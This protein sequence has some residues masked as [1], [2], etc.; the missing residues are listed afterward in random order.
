M[1]ASTC[2]DPS[3][4]KSYVEKLPLRN[5]QAAF[6]ALQSL[7]QDKLSFEPLFEVFSGIMDHVLASPDPDMA[8]A[9]LERFVSVIFSRVTFYG[10]LRSHPAVL[11]MLMRLFGSSQFL[12]DALIR[13]PEYLDW[14]AD[15]EIMK[16]QKDKEAFLRE[17]NQTLQ[18]FPKKE[19]KMHVLR[20]FKRREMLRIGTRDILGAAP[21]EITV[22]ELSHLA[23]AVMEATLALAWGECRAKYGIPMEETP[24]GRNPAAFAVI[25]MGKLGGRE[26]NYSSDIDVMFVYSAEGEV[27]APKRKKT[28]MTAHEFFNR[29]S[30]Q[31]IEIIGAK[32]KEGYVFRID[33]R[34]RPEGETGPLSR[35]LESYETYYATWGEA[36]EKL[37]LIKARPMAG[38]AKLGEDFMA[39]TRPFVYPK[40][41]H[42]A[43]LEEIRHLKKRI[44][45]KLV[46]QGA[47]YKEV[48]L[49]YGGIREIEFS[50]QLLQ[51][52]H[53]GANKR[54]RNPNTL[55]LLDDLQAAGYVNPPESQG[56]QEAYRFLRRVEH[57]LQ[58]V[59]EMQVHQLPADEEEMQKLARRIGYTDAA[60]FWKDHRRHTALVHGFHERVFGKGEAQDPA[61]DLVFLF[62]K[63]HAMKAREWLSRRGFKD[64]EQ[65]RNLLSLLAN[66]PAYMHLSAATVREFVLLAPSLMDLLAACA[67]PDMALNAFERMVSSQG[68]RGPFYKLLKENEKLLEW[69]VKL[70]S[71]SPLLADIL[72]QHP[73]FLEMLMQDPYL[74]FPKPGP[75]QCK[76]AQR[77]P[78]HQPL[79]LFKQYEILRIGTRDVLGLAELPSVMEELSDLADAVAMRVWELLKIKTSEPLAMLGM[80]KWGSREM[81]YHSDLDVLFVHEAGQEKAAP[82]EKKAQQWM[83]ACAEMTPHGS[84]YKTD[85]R[86]R[87]WGKN[88]I[89]VPSLDGYLSYAKTAMQTWER[90]AFTRLRFIGGNAALGK[91]F[92]SGMREILFSTGLTAAQVSEIQAMRERMAKERVSPAGKG[93]HVKLDAGGIVDVEFAAQM[94]ILHGGARHASLRNGVSTL[95]ALQKSRE[96]GLLGAEAAGRLRDGYLFLRS[97]ENKLRMVSGLASD[98]IPAGK[99][100][101]AAL[102][103]RMGY[104][105]KTALE[106][107]WSRYKHHT[108]AVRSEFTALCRR[109]SS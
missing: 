107:F 70:A 74:S 84:L 90:L 46:L 47:T 4:L 96:L 44:E 58:I 42:P 54:L 48:K 52:M 8:L 97:I 95:E 57:F 102:I 33:L 20:R 17:L 18:L 27:L 50:V 43:D 62:A 41:V 13:N 21:L 36:W 81:A 68:A 78:S 61:K 64:P 67:D 34:L 59:H 77:S 3:K 49:G 65:A 22:S 16:A 1:D 45:S 82:L 26:L 83:R 53:A 39:M 23:D 101:Q 89:L 93:S 38:D 103:R 11:E 24:D 106:D 98:T 51:L 14:L 19:S 7:V 6:S 37:A 71:F 66:G 25:G 60:A 63:E 105:G 100:E 30:E 2:L 29:L 31:I 72:T 99:P 80:G 10:Y 85:A 56:L 94:L 28:P 76:D 92:L 75:E 88:D 32:T 79:P 73:E 5:K 69:L 91:R 9:N 55:S 40:Q 109:L 12:S 108:A 86:L 15:P 87:P 35:S 104:A